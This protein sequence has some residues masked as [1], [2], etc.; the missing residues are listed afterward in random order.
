M[1]LISKRFSSSLGR[2]L[3]SNTG[4][5]VSRDNR[6]LWGGHL[7]ELLILE[8]CMK[9]HLSQT[10]ALLTRA[11]LRSV[12][13]FPH[14]PPVTVSVRNECQGKYSGFRERNMTTF[15]LQVTEKFKE[16]CHAHDLRREWNLSVPATSRDRMFWSHPNSLR[17]WVSMISMLPVVKAT[18]LPTC[19]VNVQRW[20][21]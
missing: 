13:L 2:H 18:F 8:D 15:Q 4:V 17:R 9:Y 1:H 10:W 14:P 7:S 3:M 5:R 21:L 19:Q 20:A 12:A 16:K 6:K 11:E